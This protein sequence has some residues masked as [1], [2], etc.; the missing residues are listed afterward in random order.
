[1]SLS[2]I[3]SVFS[4]VS[5]VALMFLVLRHGLRQ[6]VNRIFLLYLVA[7]IYWQFNALM[8]SL[9]S[10]AGQA[11]FWY[12]M[13]LTGGVFSVLYFHFTLAYLHSRTRTQSVLLMLGYGM[14]LLLGILIMT[15]PEYA[16]A[17]VHREETGL[18]VPEFAPLM[19]AYGLFVYFYLGLG[20]VNL[21]TQ[22]RRSTSELA[23]NR[24]RYLI[25]G[26]VIV[27]LG[28]FSNF[29]PGLQGYPVDIVANLT[30]A[31]LIA[32]AILR[33]QLL[34][35]SVVVRK[36]LLYSVPTAIVGA[37]YFLIVFLAVNLLHFVTGYQ[38]LILSGYGSYHGHSGPAALEPDAVLGGQATVPG[39][40]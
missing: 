8:V 35:M 24:L 31:A 16:I 26:I 28:A 4:L 20:L 15:M 32:L 37:G 14:G 11:A 29:L 6:R 27:Y 9:S 22:Y 19:Y 21:V 39:E 12:Q 5:Y 1:M 7:M 40:I 3:V 33:F 17:S 34:D 38:V 13:M 18:Y 36:G 2:I 25:S 23:R 10:N 30:N